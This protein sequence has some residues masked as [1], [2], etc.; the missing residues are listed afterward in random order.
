MTLDTLQD[1]KQKKSPGFQTGHE[2]WRV[3]WVSSDKVAEQSPTGQLKPAFWFSWLDFLS[4]PGCMR[5]DHIYRRNWA[6]KWGSVLPT[7]GR[8][9]APDLVPLSQSG[10]PLGEDPAPVSC[11]VI[12]QTVAY[13]QAHWVLPNY[14]LFPSLGSLSWL[15]SLLAHMVSS[16]HP[17]GLSE[18]LPRDS[19]WFKLRGPGILLCSFPG[20]YITAHSTQGFRQG[21]QSLLD[22]SR[23]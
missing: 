13:F 1:R 20:S 2:I 5:M 23:Y 18:T 21:T 22:A 7:V 9:P 3:G 16:G 8:K 15:Q 17:R 14:S 6:W 10:V 4:C 19:F 11:S 12:T